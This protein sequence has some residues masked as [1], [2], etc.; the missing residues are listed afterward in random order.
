MKFKFIFLFISTIFILSCSSK[1]SPTNTDTGNGGTNSYFPQTI[2][3]YWI[4]D[5]F[6]LDSANNITGSANYT[7]SVVISSQSVK[8]GKNAYVYTTYRDGTPSDTNYFY[9]DGSKIFINTLYYNNILSK[10]SVAA[11][12]PL[13]FNI[14]AGWMLHSDLN[15]STWN[16]YDTTFKNLDYLG[17]AKINGRMTIDYSKGSSSVITI[18]GAQLNSIEFITNFGFS[19]TITT[20]FSDVPVDFNYV[21]RNVYGENAGIM[22]TKFENLNINFQ[23]AINVQG[24]LSTAKRYNIK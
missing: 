4:Y 17:I 9:T 16:A 15:G 19:G 2:G 10:I 22:Q 18:N 21:I 5:N 12:A 1:N 20:P 14:P 6:S 13:P 8:D 11:Q 24:N 23:Q 7:D 3:S